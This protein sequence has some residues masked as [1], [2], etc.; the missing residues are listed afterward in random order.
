MS[1]CNQP[2]AVETNQLLTSIIEQQ[3]TLIEIQRQQLAAA[4]T[5]L[6]RESN[7][8]LTILFWNIATYICASLSIAILVYLSRNR[9]VTWLFDLIVRTATD[10]PPRR[11]NRITSC[12]SF[13]TQRVNSNTPGSDIELDEA[14]MLL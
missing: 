6:Q 3:R 5:Q 4:R 7:S 12:F 11:L 2:C 13:R 10:G 1:S 9:L 8:L 14:Q